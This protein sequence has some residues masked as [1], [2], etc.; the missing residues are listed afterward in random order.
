MQL[1]VVRAQDATLVLM[2]LPSNAVGTSTRAKSEWRQPRRTRQCHLSGQTLD[3]SLRELGYKGEISFRGEPAPN[4]C[5]HHELV[6][7]CDVRPP[8]DGEN[9]APLSS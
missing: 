9:F 7:R 6:D 5:D 3:D 8:A 1:Y 2:R 4:R